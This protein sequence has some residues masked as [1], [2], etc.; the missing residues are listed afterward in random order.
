MTQGLDEV[1]K[2]IHSIRRISRLSDLEQIQAI[3]TAKRVE[4]ISRTTRLQARNNSVGQAG[5]A[6]VKPP[7]KPK[8]RRPPG[9]TLDPAHRQDSVYKEYC[10]ALN[11]LTNYCAE[12]KVPRTA[13]P[14]FIRD[15]FKKALDAWL[16]LKPK[17]KLPGVTPSPQR[18]AGD[19]AAVQ[20]NVT[21]DGKT[22]HSGGAP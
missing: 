5:P 10:N 19:G 22:A 1:E 13:A 17:Y 6:V 18:N 15:P 7:A 16:A 8:E 3:L 4:L 11:A 21:D 20:S 9:S 12:H 14:P 2:A